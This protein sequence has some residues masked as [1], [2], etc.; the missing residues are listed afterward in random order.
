MVG[1]YLAVYLI[2]M[3]KFFAG[4]FAGLAAGLNFWESAIFTILG[5]MTT[6]L[7]LTAL[8]EQIRT[9]WM[10][11]VGKKGK[12]FTRKNRLVVKVWKK[13]GILGLSFL[14]PILLTP[15][16]GALVANMLEKDRK[17]IVAYMFYSAVFWSLVTNG[18]IYGVGK[19]AF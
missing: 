12:R 13:F 14:T 4:P 11:L 2:S 1:K 5:M 8:G 3:V 18:A 15:I 16:G 19:L 17:R 10:R 7:L 9:L 6:V